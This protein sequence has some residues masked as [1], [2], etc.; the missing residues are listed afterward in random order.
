MMLTGVRKWIVVFAALA[1]LVAACSS[2]EPDSAGGSVVEAPPKGGST[3]S[4]GPIASSGDVD[5][6]TNVPPKI[7]PSP[8]TA[9]PPTTTIVPPPPPASSDR[10]VDAV[11]GDDSRNGG[12]E[13]QA[14]QSLAFAIGQLEPGTTL[15]VMDGV[16][17]ENMAGAAHYLIDRGGT[18]EQWIRIVA[19]PGASPRIEATT[20][21]AVEIAGANYVEWSGF[22]IAGVGFSADNDFGYG[23]VARDGHHF[24]FRNNAIYGMA[25]SGIGGGEGS[26]HF[27]IS[28]NL[29]HDNALW[30]DDGSSGIS[31]WRLENRGFDDE[32]DGYS[33]RIVGNEI[34]GN[35]NR[36]ACNCVDFRAI[37]DGNGIIV[38]QNNLDHLKYTGR[39][40]IAENVVY[41]NGGKGINIYQSR[42]IDVRNNTTF[43]NAF[44]TTLDGPRTEVATYQSNDVRIENNIFWPSD[45]LPPVV[46]E[47]G[48]ASIVNNIHVAPNPGGD[49]ANNYVT[50]PGIVAPSIDPDEAD[51]RL[52]NDSL[53]LGTAVDG[54]SVG[55]LSN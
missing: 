20:D 42:R 26:S 23:I 30:S 1:L 4:A 5:N 37:T 8:T 10:Y 32:A 3:E 54:G 22:E 11:D 44:T 40:L 55:A 45:G 16:Y 52:R 43:Q 19:A 13:A 27:T 34:F 7:L 41:N 29:I 46:I 14:W 2:D 53:A 35:E 28:N 47:Q 50:D 21:S 12:S 33:N 17:D 31:L 51:F 36:K 6:Q 48:E 18:A 38:D 25:N 39:T 49:N 24:E 15:F 9:P